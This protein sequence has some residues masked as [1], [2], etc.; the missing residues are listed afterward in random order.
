MKPATRQW[1]DLADTDLRAAE[2]LCEDESLTRAVA[3][4]CQQAV[5]KALKAFLE[6]KGLPLVKTHDLRRLLG[7]VR[8]SVPI[9]TDDDQLDVIN[10][11]YVS[12]RYPLNLGMLPAGP[13]TQREVR[14]M[15]SFAQEIVE[16]IA[17]LLASE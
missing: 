17:V 9:E 15:Y 5:E 7:M 1:L 16:R 12:S 3:F 4:H 8:Q 14:A 2:T 6:E 10:Q 13:P 11:I